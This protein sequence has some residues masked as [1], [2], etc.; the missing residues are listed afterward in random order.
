[1]P[2]D[3]LPVFDGKDFP[4]WKMVIEQYLASRGLE[5]FLRSPDAVAP[6]PSEEDARLDSQAL[7]VI[8]RSL[9]IKQARHI[10]G[11]RTA[12]AAWDRLCQLYDQRSQSSKIS[13][14]RQ[15]SAVQMEKGEDVADYISRVDYLR[16]QLNDMGIA[17]SE[18]TAV[19]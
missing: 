6:A 4:V 14:Q 15:F 7:S 18:A 17:I 8:S 10:L 19:A 16:N 12:H 9:S 13:L 1:M 2:S 11:H 3:K 5:R